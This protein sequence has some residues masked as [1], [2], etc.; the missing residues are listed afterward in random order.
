MQELHEDFMRALYDPEM[1]QSLLHSPLEAMGAEE[2]KMQKPGTRAGL[3]AEETPQ[4][5]R[6]RRPAAKQLHQMAEIVIATGETSSLEISV[7]I[8]LPPGNL[9]LITNSSSSE[10]GTQAI[11]T[12]RTKRIAIW[13]A[14]IAAGLEPDTPRN[15]YRLRNAQDRYDVLILSHF[16]II[17]NGFSLCRANF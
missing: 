2:P 15:F 7:I 16:L 1:N 11:K 6:G 13:V 14:C 12:V 3:N 8:L 17:C 10:A 5:K 9:V 4:M